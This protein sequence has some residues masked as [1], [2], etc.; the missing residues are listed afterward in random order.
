MM[1]VR[2]VPRILSVAALFV[3]DRRLLYRLVFVKL[4]FPNGLFVAREV[5][6]CLVH[7]SPGSLGL[8]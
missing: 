6:A 7:L 1:F 2:S 3:W 5:L 8:E 4:A